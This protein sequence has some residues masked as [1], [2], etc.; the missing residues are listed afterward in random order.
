[1]IRLVPIVALLVVSLCASATSASAECAWVLWQHSVMGK[2]TSV[3]TEPVDAY[4]TKQAWG[5]AIL[6]ELTK[7][8]ASRSATT[9]VTVD[10]ASNSVVT[11]VKTKSGKVEPLISYSLFCLPDSVDPRGPKAR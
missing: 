5:N 8:E 4:E 2:S 10:R 3:T 6:A 9:L 11:M 7:A 1:V